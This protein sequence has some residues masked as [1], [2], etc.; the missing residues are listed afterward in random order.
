[1]CN[2]TSSTN[3]RLQNSAHTSRP[4]R[5]HE[6][7]GDFRLEDVWAFPLPSGV[8]DVEAAARLLAGFD[9]STS[10]S[11]AVRALFAIRWKAGELLGWDDPGTGVGS[12]VPTLRDGLPRDLREQRG[13]EFRGV[14]FSSV[15]LTGDEWA[16][17]IAN[18]TMHGVLHLGLVPDGVGG[19]RAQMAVLVKP[20]GLLGVAYM[21]A[22]RPFRHLV[23]YPR[24]FEDIERRVGV[25]AP[26]P[27]AVRQVEVPKAA[28]ALSSLSQIDYADAFLLRTG[29]DDDRTAGQWARTILEGSPFATRAALQSGWSSIGLKLDGESAGEHMLGWQVRRQTPDLILLGAESRIGM[30]GELLFQRRNRALLFATFLQHD[31]AVARAVWAGVEPVHLVVV[32]RLLEHAAGR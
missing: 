20:N 15:Y 23:V 16:A 5:I 19:R 29:E 30:P 6:L 3:R 8:E 26:P 22:I 32:R 4:W 2:R 27:G 11:R 12:S 7:T 14:P 25:T 17:E 31:N 10:S 28:R 21:A 1:M 18:R 13:P 9:P 24:L